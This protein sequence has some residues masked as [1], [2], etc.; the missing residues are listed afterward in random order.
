[1]GLFEKVVSHLDL[2][3]RMMNRTGAAQRLHAAGEIESGI[4]SAMARCSG[5][6]DDKACAEWLAHAPQDSAPPAFCRNSAFFA[7][8]TA[9]RE[10]A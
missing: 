3:S 8:L 4:R 5:C 10:H 1:M 7:R 6:T 2:M 9:G